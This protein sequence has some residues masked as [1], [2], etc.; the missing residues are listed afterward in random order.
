M[1]ALTLS[2]SLPFAM[3][4]TAGHVLVGGAVVGL[5]QGLMLARFWGVSRRRAL[6]QMV[7]ACYGSMLLVLPSA[8]FLVDRYVPLALLST[9]APWLYAAVFVA[10]L[11]I[12]WPFVRG[13]MRPR[14]RVATKSALA[15]TILNALSFS[16]LFAL[17]ASTCNI[18][19]LRLQLV[20]AADV[21][22]QSDPVVFYVDAQH[23]SV[24]RTRPASMDTRIA[25]QYHGEQAPMIVGH[26][27]AVDACLP[28]D[29][30]GRDW[31]CWG[32]SPEDA[33]PHFATPRPREV[34]AV[35]LRTRTSAWTFESGRQGVGLR[36]HEAGDSNW[37]SVALNAPLI[38]R[39]VAQITVLPGDQL[40][41]QVGREVCVLDWPK[42]TLSVLAAGTEPYVLL[43]EE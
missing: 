4:E 7:A 26:E 28:A 5:F 10:T 8:V 30:A 16:M 1:V 34:V 33:Q 36:V 43:D 18:G 35:D 32:L 37:Q 42:R 11:L 20:P 12:Q 41:L 38:A 25:M 31:T 19:I 9:V 22:W 40:V 6:V 27:G 23:A 29:S 15:C 13:A 24:M 17:Y 39:R 3:G 21:A 14:S 2:M